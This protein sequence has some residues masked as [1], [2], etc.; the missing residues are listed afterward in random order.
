MRLFF[1]PYWF[2]FP[3]FS[4]QKKIWGA[5]ARIARSSKPGSVLC[6]QSCSHLSSFAIAHEVKRWA[7]IRGSRYL[8]LLAANRVYP[9]PLSPAESVS[10]CLTLFTLTPVET[11]AVWFLWHFSYACARLPL[12]TIVSCAARTFLSPFFRPATT[13]N[14]L[15]CIL[16]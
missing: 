10:S 15:P 14:E 13:L 1:V 8:G 5:L 9:T 7:T 16:A 6:K 3:N 12:A 2:L 11:G 4:F